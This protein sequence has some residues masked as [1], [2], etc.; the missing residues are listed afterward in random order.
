MTSQPALEGR[1]PFR[2]AIFT[3]TYDDVNGVSS[4]YRQFVAAANASPAPAARLAVFTMAERSSTEVGPQATVR[5]YRPRPRLA[6]PRYPQLHTGYPPRRRIA[7][8]FVAGGFDAVVV[9]T[10]GPIGFRGLAAARQAG[11]PVI[12]FYHTRFP[13]YLAVYARALGRRYVPRA[14]ERV[15][16]HWMRRLYG[17]CRLVVC[18]SATIV[19]EI[20]RST[21]AEVAVWDTGVDLG[22]F[23][24]GPAAE[25]RARHGLRPDAVVVLY[26]GRVAVEKGL[27][28]LVPLA[29]E[30]PELD[31][32]VVGDG[33]YLGQLTAQAPATF[34]GF[35]TGQALADA[36][37]AAD[38]FFFPSVTDTFGNVLLEAMASGLPLVVTDGGPGAELVARTGAGLD[39]PAGDV[40]AAV[41]A[42]RRLAGDPALRREMSERA[43]SHAAERAWPLAFER[44]A[45]LCRGVTD[46]G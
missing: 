6:L 32:L 16:Y 7:A 12:G 35:L 14:A 41:A 8:D 22:L 31:F 4:I 9:A 25:I 43:R 27:E 28:A 40:S 34:T 30:L 3:D 33:P 1:A 13:A 10:P 39:F 23:S 2:L 19:P 45:A 37:R 38:L 46:R 29:R 36:Y 20:R 42:L 5:R 26:V 17:P 21:A 24:P 11:L 44:F 18:Q 15:G